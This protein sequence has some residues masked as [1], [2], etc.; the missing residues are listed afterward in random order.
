MR[1]Q[2]AGSRRQTAGTLGREGTPTANR[3]GPSGSRLELLDGFD[4][5]LQGTND[6]LSAVFAL[7]VSGRSEET[8]YQAEVQQVLRFRC[9]A[10]SNVEEPQVVTTA[11]ACRSFRDIRGDGQGGPSQL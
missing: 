10:E 4:Q 1:V 5:S 8:D 11:P 3:L 9:R 6:L 2:A 7:A